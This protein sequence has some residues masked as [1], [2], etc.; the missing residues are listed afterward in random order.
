MRS[1]SLIGGG[2]RLPNRG[3]APADRLI[4]GRTVVLEVRDGRVFVRP[5]GRA[6]S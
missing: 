6:A 5:R 2:R 1:K 3:G 4:V